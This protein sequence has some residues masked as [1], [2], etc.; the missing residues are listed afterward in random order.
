MIA[1]SIIEASFQFRFPSIKFIS[2]SKFTIASLS[3]SPGLISLS[4]TQR[5]RS[6]GLILSLEFNDTSRY[7]PQ[8]VSTRALYSFSGSITITSVPIIRLLRISS[9]T[10]NDFQPQDLANTHIFAFSLLNLS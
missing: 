4:F 7:E 6:K 3:K 5:G 1:F 8:T 2:P 9:L 10:A